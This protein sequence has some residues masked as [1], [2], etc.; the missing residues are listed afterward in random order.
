[1]TQRKK[2]KLFGIKEEE[3]S[4]QSEDGEVSSDLIPISKNPDTIEII[5]EQ[6]QIFENQEHSSTEEILLVQ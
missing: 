1:M 5:E 2:S 3:Y 6:K 4:S